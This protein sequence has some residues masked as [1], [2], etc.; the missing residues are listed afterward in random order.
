MIPSS[1]SR[2]YSLRASQAWWLA[3][4]LA[5]VAILLGLGVRVSGEVTRLDGALTAAAWRLRQ[6]WL[7]ET[8][9][10]L[11]GFGDGLPRW[12]VTALVSVYLLATRRYRWAV[13]LIGAMVACALLGPVLKLA[14]HTPRPSPLYAG[15]DAFS[16]PSGHALSAAALYTILGVLAAEGLAKPWGRLA[17]ALAAV[18]V[19]SISL[20]RVYLGAHWFSDVLAGV[21]LGAALAIVAITLARAGKTGL[22]EADWRISIAILVCIGVVAAGTGATTLAKAHRLY[23][24]FLRTAR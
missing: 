4:A 20:S 14:F 6:P 16:F 12:C 2:P 24:P 15:V 5:L 1:A 10:S 17:L 22:G 11:S 18:L 7:D 3:L 23:A 21:A 13:A 9:M 19:V 8:M